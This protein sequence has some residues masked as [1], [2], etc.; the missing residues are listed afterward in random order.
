MRDFQVIRQ[1]ALSNRVVIAVYKGEK[2][3]EGGESLPAKEPGEEYQN[4]EDRKVRW[5][6]MRTGS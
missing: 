6:A 2:R 3:L 5:I 4:K 1:V